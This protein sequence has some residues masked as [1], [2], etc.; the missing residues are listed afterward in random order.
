MRNGKSLFFFYHNVSSRNKDKSLPSLCSCPF[1]DE[2]ESWAARIE[3]E[4]HGNQHQCRWGN[5][6]AERAPRVSKHQGKEGR[7]LSFRTWTLALEIQLETQEETMK[8]VGKDQLKS[9]KGASLMWKESAF[10]GW[11]LSKDELWL[12]LSICLCFQE[13]LDCMGVSLHILYKPVT[14]THHILTIP[15]SEL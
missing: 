5:Q 8:R 14:F 4:T 10:R 7:R 15:P 12:P 13:N 3:G 11:G 1:Q 9:I 2:A 6:A